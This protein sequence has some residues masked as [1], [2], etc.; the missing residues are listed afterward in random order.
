MLLC[1]GNH[2][3][4]RKMLKMDEL[5]LAECPRLQQLPKVPTTPATGFGHV[6]QS[7]RFLL[8]KSQRLSCS[9]VKQK[10]EFLNSS[11]FGSTPAVRRVRLNKG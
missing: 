6:H 3:S 7:V 10:P 9:R 5:A 8:V 4:N 11:H 1:D 2:S